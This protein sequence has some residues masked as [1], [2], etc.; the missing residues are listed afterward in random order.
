MEYLS[1]RAIFWVM[2]PLT[3]LGTLC[4][5]LGMPE[6]RGT[7]QKAKIDWAGTL[8]LTAATMA[9]LYLLSMGG[10]QF[11]WLSLTTL[12]LA[13]ASAVCLCLLL[14]VEKR[15]AAPIVPLHLFREDVFL[16]GLA[17]VL[18]AAVSTC[19]I[20]YL[21]SF[22]QQ[23]M[24]MSPTLSGVAVAPRQIA[25]I[26]T[27]LALGR[28]LGRTRAYKKPSLLNAGL[29]ILSMGLMILFSRST[30]FWIVCLA[31]SL[32]GCANSTGNM[33]PRSIGQT[34]FRAEDL[35]MGLAFIT[36]VGTIGS[37]VGT[38]PG[39]LRRERGGK[40][41]RPPAPAHRPAGHPGPG[42]PLRLRPHPPCPPLPLEPP[43]GWAR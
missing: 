1:W 6:G 13:A 19:V 15:A 31:E 35:G 14:A 33:L 29:F 23:I 17:I 21:P 3:A 12:L 37:S 2:L 4:T 10:K 25:T 7:R 28:Y 26:L 18:V 9:L 41:R 22:Y 38:H 30:P 20:N 39:G 42:L 16:L 43:V 11:P 34:G 24:G 8:L 5:F 36:F 40:R 27:S 32:Y